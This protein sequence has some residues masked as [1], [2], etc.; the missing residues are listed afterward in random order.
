MTDDTPPIVALSISDDPAT[1]A[2]FGYLPHHLRQV[3][4]ELLIILLGAGLR[5]GYGGDLRKD[6]YTRELFEVLS[7]AYDGNQ[8]QPKARPAI[9]HY[10]AFSSWSPTEPTALAEHLRSIGKTGET[11]F[12]DP[13]GS[14]FAVFGAEQA[15]RQVAASGDARRI[16][17]DELVAELGRRREVGAAVSAPDAL[18]AMRRTMAQ[19]T[20]IRVVASGK[21]AD[22]QGRMPG[23]VEEAL[24]HAAEGRLVVPLGAF[25]GASRDV[26]IALGLLLEDARVGYAKT[27]ESYYPAPAELARLADAHRRCAEEKQVWQELRMLADA[28][29]PT[30]IAAGV[31]RAVRRAVQAG[32]TPSG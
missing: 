17:G 5:I 30:V 23:I 1:L 26:A 15:F 29:D 8:L 25:G 6:G 21:V 9:V 20:I 18:T 12:C 4:G 16:Q 3:L 31:L 27:G 24:L 7:A 10:F 14:Y 28:D 2:R 11:R 32:S 13:S 22:Y 19:E